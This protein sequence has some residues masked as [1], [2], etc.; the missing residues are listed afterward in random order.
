MSENLNQPMGDARKYNRSP[1]VWKVNSADSEIVNPGD[2]E[3]SLLRVNSLIV[4]PH[5]VN[6]IHSLIVILPGS[7]N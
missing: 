1:L 5:S 4:T 6:Q 2:Y 3:V 7:A